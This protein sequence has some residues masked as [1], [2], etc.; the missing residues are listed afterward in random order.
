MLDLLFIRQRDIELKHFVIAFPVDMDL[1]LILINGHVFANDRQQFSFQG[2]Q[3]H[4][5]FAPMATL[6]SDD[7]LQTLF[8][9][10]R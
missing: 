8:C 10:R 2:W 6:M 7:D 9:D 4:R 1:D 3:I 5:A